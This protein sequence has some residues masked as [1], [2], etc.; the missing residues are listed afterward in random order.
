MKEGNYIFD[1]FSKI[2]IYKSDLTVEDY[3]LRNN[4]FYYKLLITISCCYLY[5]STLYINYY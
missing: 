2:I 1:S 5:I 4:I 3:N